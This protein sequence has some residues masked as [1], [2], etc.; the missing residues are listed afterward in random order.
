MQLLIVHRD[1][2][3]GEALVQ[4][5]KSYTRHQWELAGSDVAAMD[6]ARR[7]QQCN[8]LLTQLGAD[9]IDG[10]ALGSSLSEIF[11]ALQVLFFPNYP[12]AERRLE[13][14]ETKVFPEP[15]EGDDLLAAIERAENA[16]PNAPDLFHVV[17]VLQ[18]CC[19]SRRNG[20]LQLV[21]ES[22]SGLVFLRGGKIV[23][24]ETI[25]ARG[26]DALLEMVSWEFIEFAYERSVR[27]PLQTITGAW[28]DILIDVITALKQEN[29]IKLQRRSA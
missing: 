29:S 16:P 7:H 21:K 18:M 3:M 8:L 26:R 17:D 25:A 4:M 27:A 14:A 20:A 11:P 10:L 1:S 5:V 24:A 15:I 6:W 9:G 28:H 22:R 2:E 12:A 23:H 19:L 13:I